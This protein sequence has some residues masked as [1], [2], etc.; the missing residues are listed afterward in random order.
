MLIQCN[1]QAYIWYNNR[2]SSLGLKKR[3]YLA[4]HHFL[5]QK[6]REDNKGPEPVYVASKEDRVKMHFSEIDCVKFGINKGN[7]FTV[8]DKPW[9]KVIADAKLTGWRKLE[10]KKSELDVFTP[11]SVNG[12]D[13][14]ERRCWMI[15]QQ[16]KSSPQFQFLAREHE[17]LP[18]QY[19]NLQ[20]EFE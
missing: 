9:S 5:L 3:Q 16:K 13:P 2:V 17:A 15:E 6:L 7:F 10:Q 19:S 18:A 20:K 4:F 14:E 11:P 8:P 12:T 1:L